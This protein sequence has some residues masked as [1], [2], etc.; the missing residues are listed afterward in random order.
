[1]I[2]N[3]PCFSMGSCAVFYL[4][5]SARMVGKCSVHRP[6]IGKVKMVS[7]LQALL[8]SGLMR[9]RWEYEQRVF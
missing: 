1:M 5:I 8:N 9:L 3:L 6:F 4:V 7:A 2:A